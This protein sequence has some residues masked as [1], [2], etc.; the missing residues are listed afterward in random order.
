MAGDVEAYADIRPKKVKL[1]G[2]AG[3]EIKETV[4]I[5][6]KDKYP[7]HV[8]DAKAKNGK[9]IKVN[10]EKFEKDRGGRYVLTIENTR[11]DQGNYYD[12]VV[13]NTDSKIQPEITIRVY[14]HIAEAKPKQ[15]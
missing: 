11:T 5:E 2:D 8:L 10:L 4:T 15:G 9:F 13:L 3:Q 6:T 14:G 7:F 1:K 12:A